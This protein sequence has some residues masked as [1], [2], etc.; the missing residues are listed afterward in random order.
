MKRKKR[1]GWVRRAG[2]EGRLLLLIRVVTE[3]FLEEA[4]PEQT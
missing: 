4:W 3:V 2:G 1:Q